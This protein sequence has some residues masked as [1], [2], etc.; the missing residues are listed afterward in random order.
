MAEFLR[1]LEDKQCY[2]KASLVKQH[3]VLKDAEE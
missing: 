3:A 2:K 1:V